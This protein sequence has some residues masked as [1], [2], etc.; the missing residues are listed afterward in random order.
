VDAAVLRILTLKLRIYENVFSPIRVA[1]VLPVG[2][3]DTLGETAVRTAQQGATLINPSNS[4]LAERYQAPPQ[5][6]ERIVFFTDVQLQQQCSTCEPMSDL[7]RDALEE[8][9]LRFY[10]Q[11]GAR[12]VGAW[13]L[14][15][16]TFADLS[17]YLGDTPPVGSMIS[18]A[19]PEDVAS[20]IENADWIVF[21]A[22]DSSGEYYGA[23]ALKLFLDR[24]PDLARGLQTI[25]FA[26]DVPFALDATDISKLDIYYGL[27]SSS[28]AFIESAARLLFF[29][30]TAPGFSPVDIDGIG[31]HLS[32]ITSPA[33][34]QIIPLQASLLGGTLEEGETPEFTIGDV[35][36]LEAGPILDANGH[37]VPDGTVVQFEMADQSAGGVSSLLEATTMD[38]YAAVDFSLD[39]VGLHS[40][41]TRSYPALISE[42]VQ[43]NVQE[44]IP[45]VA[46]VISPT[47]VP[48]VTL[49]PTATFS[50]EVPTLEPGEMNDD[51]SEG[52]EGSDLEPGSLLVLVVMMAVLMGIAQLLSSQTV[53]LPEGGIRVG[54]IMCAAGLIGYNY[55]SLL[56]PGSRVI[57]A[58]MGF[59]AVPL[60][61]LG[62]GLLGLSGFL[63]VN[64]NQSKR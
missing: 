57:L 59:F 5:L 40:I 12:L 35:I 46:T 43:L 16:F 64:R 38:G 28:Q 60:M 8:A 41:S 31:Y 51:V 49:P 21:S 62:A 53:L 34:F 52:V 44:D 48:T 18:V 23:N 42:V 47:L 9:V 55:L 33:E 61:T 36:H 1:P 30:L 50:T 19:A 26:F 17:H 45:A 37:I 13:S 25:A 6:G 39:R 27:Y 2:S 56:L 24:R 32:E 4:E 29:E 10:G 63:I 22:L 7:T 54:L 15:S 3:M 11:E 20:A 58:T 14:Q